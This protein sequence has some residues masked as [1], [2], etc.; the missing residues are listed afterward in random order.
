M[1]RAATDGFIRS[2]MVRYHGDLEPNMRPIDA[3]SPAPWNY[4]NGDVELICESIEQDGMYRP[5]VAQLSTG[6]IIGG[7]HTYMACLALGAKEIPVV[8]LD[9]NDVTAKRLAIKDNEIAR[10]SKPDTGLLQELLDQIK[11]AEPD[12]PLDSTGITEEEY[13]A[14][15]A[16]NA[17]PVAEDEFGSWPTLT[18]QL[19]PHIMA[20][21]VGMTDA[22]EKDWQRVEILLRMAG[23]DSK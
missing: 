2:G 3:V 1:T 13:A 7:N 11:E 14:L 17:I 6:H 9:V 15:R 4:N 19:P 10:K 21:F 20:A 23:W 5:V 16:L 8:F 18:V 12:T 22:A